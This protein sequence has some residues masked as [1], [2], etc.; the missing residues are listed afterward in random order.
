VFIS[1]R[2]G[3]ASI[4]PETAETGPKREE[5]G[6]EEVYDLLALGL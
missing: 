3:I 2:L 5:C 4:P 1:E 6:V